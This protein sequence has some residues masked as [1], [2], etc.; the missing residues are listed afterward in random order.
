MDVRC[1]SIDMRTRC[2]QKEKQSLAALGSGG[3]QKECGAGTGGQFAEGVGM[4]ETSGQVRSGVHW[5]SERMGQ[6]NLLIGL[7]EKQPQAKLEAGSHGDFH[8][9]ASGETIICGVSA[10]G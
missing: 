7:L 5:E 6:P 10:R 2:S 9:E 4:A 8:R 1:A 3:F